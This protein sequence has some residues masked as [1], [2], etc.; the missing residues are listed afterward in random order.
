MKPN[1]R[2]V[3]LAVC[4]VFEVFM[5]GRPAWA[6]ERAYSL[7]VVAKVDLKAPN[8]PKPQGLVVETLENYALEQHDETVTVIING[9][10]VKMVNDGKVVK[11]NEMS[12]EEA[13]FQEGGQPKQTFPYEKA[14]ASLKQV[15]DRFGKPVARIKLDE[16]GAETSRELLVEKNSTLVESGVIDNALIF[17][18]PFPE[19]KE[20]WEA[21]VRFSIGG[22]QYAQGT[23]KY[24]KEGKGLKD[25]EKVSVSGEL[26]A[27]GKI[28][29]GEVKNGTYKLEGSEIYDRSKS[30]WVSGQLTAEMNLEVLA[31]GQP[32]GAVEG[33]MTLT[34]VEG[35][36]KT[37]PKEAVTE[38]APEDAKAE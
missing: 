27:E 2:L 11:D 8:Q 29:V 22:G 28:G 37:V 13:V 3:I 34:L 5:A 4:V 25:T 31:D 1:R 6:E 32:A 18:P 7:S 15:M 24:K 20:E 12:R 14:P 9:L 10:H 30:A 19:D 38:K 17:H 35:T 23:L 36:V 21:P 33:T 26:K 16:T